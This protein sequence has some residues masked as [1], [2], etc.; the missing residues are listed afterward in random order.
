MAESEKAPAVSG[1]P[2]NYYHCVDNNSDTPLTNCQRELSSERFFRGIDQLFLDRAE[3]ENKSLREENYRLKSV[4]S[5][6]E[7]KLEM[8]VRKERIFRSM[9]QHVVGE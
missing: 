5:E 1:A 9:Y 4:K 6:L 2:S 7:T 8:A 3:R